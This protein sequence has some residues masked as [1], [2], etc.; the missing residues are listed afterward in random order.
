M[1]TAMLAPFR[2]GAF[3]PESAFDGI[4]ARAAAKLATYAEYRRTLAELRALTDRQR[5]DLGLA[6]LDV[7]AV[8]HSA[9]YEN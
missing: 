8:A 4:L 9:A 7:K 3:N 5:E 2:P 6:G 1:T